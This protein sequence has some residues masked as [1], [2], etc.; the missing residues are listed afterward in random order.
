MEI[1]SQINAHKDLSLSII[2]I[3]YL[4][5]TVQVFTELYAENLPVMAL[6]SGAKVVPPSRQTT[7]VA[8]SN[9]SKCSGI[10]FL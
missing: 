5:Q 3:V 6:N 4:T 1:S 9:K 10:L 2:T 7:H 8:P